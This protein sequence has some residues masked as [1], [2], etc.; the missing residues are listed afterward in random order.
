MMMKWVTGA[1]LSAMLWNGIFVVLRALE[2]D[3]LTLGG[4]AVFALVP[5]TVGIAVAGVDRLTARNAWSPRI[6][7]LRP[8]HDG[9]AADL[10]R[11]RRHRA[12]RHFS[13]WKPDA[14]DTI[15]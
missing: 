14:D 8:R 1:V 13:T 5:A 3:L 4:L 11:L 6:L 7:D 12:C 15:H 10:D 2:T 9:H